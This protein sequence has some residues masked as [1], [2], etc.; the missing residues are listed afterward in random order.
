M[1]GTSTRDEQGSM[2]EP[3]APADPARESVSDSRPPWSL[4]L[5]LLIGGVYIG[6][7]IVVGIPAIVF[8][9]LTMP[10]HQKPRPDAFMAWP[11][12][13]WATIGA[14]AISALAALTLTWLFLRL[15]VE[16]PL[17]ALGFVRGRAWLLLL[18]PPLTFLVMIGITAVATFFLGLDEVSVETQEVLFETPA[19]G[20]VSALVVSLFAPP[21]EEILFRSL[22]FEPVRY[23]LGGGWAVTISAALFAAAH[24]PMV[25]TGEAIIGLLAIW[26]SLGVFLG[27]LRLQ[28]GTLWG[29]VLGHATWNV[30]A[31]LAALL[32]LYLR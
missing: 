31:S 27:A 15:R 5:P 8:W 10:P 16:R 30:V 21:T 24:L 2:L 28:T 17:A 1:S 19:L 25:S 22:I 13:P 11:L 6:G 14:A 9:L 3:A 32:A 26:F 20:I 7:Q 4:W 18:T 29:P 23:R 12:F